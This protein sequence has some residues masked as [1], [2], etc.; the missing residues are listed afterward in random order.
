MDNLFQSFNANISV[1]NFAEL[2]GSVFNWLEEYCK[3]Q[4]MT[5]TGWWIKYMCT[6]IANF[7]FTWVILCVVKCLHHR[8]I[9]R[10][11]Y[12]GCATSPL[13]PLFEKIVIC[14]I[15]SPTPSPYFLPYLLLQNH[16]SNFNPNWHRVNE[17]SFFV[18]TKGNTFL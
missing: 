5:S 7:N 15:P 9:F 17:V 13:L 6:I 16:W 14:N 2:S 10:Q 11:R 12:D 8:G 18:E 4:V 1:S 3:P